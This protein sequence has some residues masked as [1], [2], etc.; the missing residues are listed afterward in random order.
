M[1]NRA[2]VKYISV[3]VSEELYRLTAE[4]ADR[5]GI[6]MIDVAV[7]ALANYVGFPNLGIVPRNPQ[8]RKRA[9]QMTV[10]ANGN[11]RKK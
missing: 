4:E 5:Q 10:K 1:E 6:K 7:Q 9:D 2:M 8:G 3:K 11:G